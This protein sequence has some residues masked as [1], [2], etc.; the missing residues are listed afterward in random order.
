MPEILNSLT[1]FFGRKSNE[2][3]TMEGNLEKL[4]KEVVKSAELFKNQGDSKTARKLRD[5]AKELKE[6]PGKVIKELKAF[7]KK[8]KLSPE[9]K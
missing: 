1:R 9:T 5:M 2:V 7:L 8:A 6:A 3:M 4:G